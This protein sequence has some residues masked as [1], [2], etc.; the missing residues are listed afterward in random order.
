[1]RA[2]LAG[3]KVPRALWLVD[4]IRRSPSGKPDYRWAQQHAGAHEPV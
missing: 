4:E 2:T 1:V 3:Y